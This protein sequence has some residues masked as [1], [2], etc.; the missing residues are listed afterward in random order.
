MAKR[1]PVR[2]ALI[3]SAM[4]LVLAAWP[5]VAG[6]QPA[7]PA[8]ASEPAPASKGWEFATITYVW[9]AG[10]EGDVDVIGPVEPVGLDLSFGD[11][12][13]SFKFAFMGAA[14]A[15]HDR[16]VLLG[17]LTFI[18]LE[19]NKGIDIRDQDFVDAELDSRTIDITALGG[20]RVVDKGKMA[21]DV[22]GGVRANFFKN[23]LQ[24]VGPNREAEGSVSETW[25]DPLIAGRIYVPLGGKWGAS[26]Y[27]DIGGFGVA[28]DLTWQAV[29]GV[30]YQLNRKFRLQ[31]GWRHF[32]VD[33]DKG[34][35]LYDVAQS[36]LFLA[37]RYQ[38]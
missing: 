6:A 32:K 7:D 10:A 21:V 24:L 16:L 5:G 4:A 27:G 29:A 38:F 13:D 34:D 26:V 14:E 23:S 2:A 12:L 8:A 31:A 37:A 28:S 30:D 36:G 15:R 1:R 22:L 18:H 33:Y 20:Y 35:F 11:V 19:A 3:K 9:M 25:F 17:D